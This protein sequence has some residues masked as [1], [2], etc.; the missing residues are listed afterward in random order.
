MFFKAPDLRTNLHPGLRFLQMAWRGLSW[1]VT[2]CHGLSSVFP[3]ILG[4]LDRYFTNLQP[5]SGYFQTACR[6]LSYIVVN[7]RL[8][9]NNEEG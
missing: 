2:L 4:C 5:V 3:L 9:I 8:R 7:C 6:I 1:F